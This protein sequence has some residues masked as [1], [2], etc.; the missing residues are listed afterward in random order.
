MQKM[1]LPWNPIQKKSLVRV[2]VRAAI[3]ATILG[4]VLAILSEIFG[5]GFRS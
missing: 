4:F 2:L 3:A 5:W 1:K